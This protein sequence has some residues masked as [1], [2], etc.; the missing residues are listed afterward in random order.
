MKRIFIGC[1]LALVASAALVAVIEYDPG[2]VLVSI[3]YYTL[4]STLVVSL[5]ALLLLVLLVYG[6]I[7]LVRR[8]FTSSSNFGSDR[9]SSK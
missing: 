2:Y 5:V 8:T 6:T 4:E 1:L 9:S 7:T 3:G